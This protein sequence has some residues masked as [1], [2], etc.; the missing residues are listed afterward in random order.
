[1]NHANAQEEETRIFSAKE[2]LVMCAASNVIM[3]SIMADDPLGKLI[4]D[5]A[6]R[7]AKLSQS[8]GADLE[9]L[10]DAVTKMENAYKRGSL[11]SDLIT[12]AVENCLNVDLQSMYKLCAAANAVLSSQMKNDLLGNIIRSEVSRHTEMAQQLGV[13]RAEIEEDISGYLK[14]FNAGQISWGEIS[15]YAESCQSY[16]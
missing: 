9:E 4:R 15:D 8:V 16:R 14:E 10:K 13:T 1:M 5:D 2:H 11:S 3:A 12:D 6:N 7:Y